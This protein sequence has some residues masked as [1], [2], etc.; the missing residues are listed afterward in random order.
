MHIIA[1]NQCQQLNKTTQLYEYLYA[2]KKIY[3]E[4]LRNLLKDMEQES[5]RVNVSRHKMCSLCTRNSFF[6]NLC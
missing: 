1:N 2:P 3:S 6:S 4:K 5:G